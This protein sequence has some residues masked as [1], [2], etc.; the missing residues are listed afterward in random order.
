MSI[1]AKLTKYHLMSLIMSTVVTTVDNSRLM[2][3]EM[4][5]RISFTT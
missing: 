4:L 2:M 3:F 1:R 5:W